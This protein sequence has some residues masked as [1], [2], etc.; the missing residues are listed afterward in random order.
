MLRQGLML[1]PGRTLCR[2]LAFV[3][4][5]GK[6]CWQQRSKTTRFKPWED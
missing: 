6:A 4:A 5:R 2:D 3:W 1:V